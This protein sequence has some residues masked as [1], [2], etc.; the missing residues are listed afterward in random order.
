MLE[1]LSKDVDGGGGGGEF[2]G[3][4][5]GLLPPPSSLP[6]SN[7]VELFD[8]LAPNRNGHRV[9]EE[10]GGTAGSAPL[11]LAMSATSFWQRLQGRS[12]QE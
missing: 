11:A 1:L 12:Q 5:I 9:E 4:K 2:R 3:T 7:E 10:G 6:A 8:I